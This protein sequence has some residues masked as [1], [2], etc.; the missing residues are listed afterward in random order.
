[1]YQIVSVVEYVSTLI[2]VSMDI[3]SVF[4]SVCVSVSGQ[5]CPA[6][7]EQLKLK[8]HFYLVFE[9]QPVLPHEQLLNANVVVVELSLFL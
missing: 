6:S 4:V 3:D 5:V 9:V 2:H 7:S 1:M 8:T